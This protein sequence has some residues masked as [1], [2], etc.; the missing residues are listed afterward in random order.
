MQMRAIRVSLSYFIYDF[1]CCLLDVRI[2]Y[3]NAVHHLV[4]IFGLAYGYLKG[5]V[6]ELII[7]TFGSPF[8]VRFLGVKKS[9]W[10]I[11]GTVKGEEGCGCE[12]FPLQ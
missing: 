4:T 9:Q 11:P 10:L 12:A 8:N 5:T 1:F 7:L 2:D 3:S 6:S